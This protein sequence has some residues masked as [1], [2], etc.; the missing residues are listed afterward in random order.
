MRGDAAGQAEEPEWGG[1]GSGRKAML[2]T[3]MGGN[4]AWTRCLLSQRLEPEILHLTYN[5]G[6]EGGRR[7]GRFVPGQQPAEAPVLREWECHTRPTSSQF[8][9]A[10]SQAPYGLDF[11]EAARM[12]VV[13]I[14]IV[15]RPAAI[16]GTLSMWQAGLRALHSAVTHYNSLRWYHPR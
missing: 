14:G 8:G 6:G 15:R 10:L 1:G 5:S 2:R 9:L 3:T 16:C 7:G 12:T 4:R 13:L 11:T